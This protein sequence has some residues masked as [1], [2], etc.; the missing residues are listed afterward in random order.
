MT[1]LVGTLMSG[2]RRVGLTLLDVV[3]GERSWSHGSQSMALQL[4]ALASSGSLLEMHILKWE[5]AGEGQ[6]QPG[7]KW[8]F[9]GCWSQQAHRGTA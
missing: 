8:A 5:S 4:A 9:Q 3:K 6:P 2:L 7:F 1:A